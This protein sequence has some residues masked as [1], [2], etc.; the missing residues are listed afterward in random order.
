MEWGVCFL[1]LSE[2]VHMQRIRS[3]VVVLVEAIEIL[4]SLALKRLLSAIN[5]SREVAL[6]GREGGRGHSKI[7][8]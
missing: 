8:S 1:H 6:S 5:I 3:H 2:S 4:L 7:C